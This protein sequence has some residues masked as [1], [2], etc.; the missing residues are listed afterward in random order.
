MK[1]KKCNTKLKIYGVTERGEWKYYCTKCNNQTDFKKR[2][3]YLCQV[4]CSQSL[5]MKKQKDYHLSE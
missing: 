3:E 5:E 2:G 4:I 1:N